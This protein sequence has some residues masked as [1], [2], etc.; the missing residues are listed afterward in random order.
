MVRFVVKFLMSYGLGCLLCTNQSEQKHANN[1]DQDPQDPNRKG[2]IV[3]GSRIRRITGRR[4]YTCI[5][6]QIAIRVRKENRRSNRTIKIGKLLIVETENTH[7]LT[8]WITNNG[9]K[10]IGTIIGDA[11][12]RRI[13]DR[14]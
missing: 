4:N 14:K 9:T 2:M 5:T 1:R 13:V 11:V 3:I 10:F 6:V 12:G 7:S 8:F